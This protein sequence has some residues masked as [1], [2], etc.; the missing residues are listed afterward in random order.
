MFKSGFSEGEASVIRVRSV[1]A[2]IC[3]PE[4]VSL[5]GI[6]ETVIVPRKGDNNRAEQVAK[7]RS[8]DKG[9]DSC[10]TRTAFL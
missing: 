1:V 8:K 4:T 2:K 6:Q 9:G 10:N 7:N 3:P 5:R